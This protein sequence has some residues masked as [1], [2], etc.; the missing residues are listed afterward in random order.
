MNH[1]C[2]RSGTR[3]FFSSN[4][5]SA[6][7]LS[8]KM[9]A[10]LRP[11]LM[12]TAYALNLSSW[13]AEAGGRMDLVRTLGL[14]AGTMAT[15]VADH[16]AEPTFYDAS[17]ARSVRLQLLGSSLLLG[18]CCA[19]DHHIFWTTL[20]FVAMAAFYDTPMPVIGWRIKRLFPCSK[21]L[22]VPA[23]HVGWCFC[24]SGTPWHWGVGLLMFATYVL[25][26][27]AMDIKDIA[28]DRSKGVVTVP[29]LIGAD[30]T[31]RALQ[32]G[33][34]AVAGAAA[35]L[36][37][38]GTVVQ[39]LAFGV[40]VRIV[41]GTGRPPNAVIYGFEITRYLGHLFLHKAS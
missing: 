6:I 41:Q 38:W 16:M 1:L 23:M 39:M 14:G 8:N 26:N 24:L 18:V 32:V 4:Q 36:A 37:S 28:E 25:I 3:L 5:G 35:A 9:G 29:T 40:H 15:Y 33:S 21:T 30:A 20:C 31:L 2:G 12:S 27:V 17:G 11:V 10:W 19:V 22:F 34:V 13:V 7:A